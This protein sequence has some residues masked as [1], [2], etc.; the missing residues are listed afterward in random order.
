MARTNPKTGKPWTVAE[1]KAQ[2]RARGIKEGSKR[3]EALDRARGIP[4]EPGKGQGN[5]RQPPVKSN[6]LK[7]GR[8]QG[9]PPPPMPP[10]PAAPLPVPP[11]VRPPIRRRRRPLGPPVPPLAGGPLRPPMPPLGR[12]ALPGIGGGDAKIK[13]RG[14]RD[15]K[16]NYRAGVDARGRRIGGHRT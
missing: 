11:G 9:G 2:D 3:D 7:V 6:S 13:G 1:D 8:G 15:P 14:Q 5:R 16:G 4:E 12:P 10:P